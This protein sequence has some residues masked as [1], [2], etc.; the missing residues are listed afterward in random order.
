MSKKAVNKVSPWVIDEYANPEILIGT[1]KAKLI[2]RK[3]SD[4]GSNK[5]KAS[6]RQKPKRRK[7]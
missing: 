4:A 6:N 1:T 3:A 2:D 7:R 5:T